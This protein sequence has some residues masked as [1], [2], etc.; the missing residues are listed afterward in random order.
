MK[1]P[2]AVCDANCNI[3]GSFLILF[4]V[5]QYMDEPGNSL[6]TILV[7]PTIQIQI[8]NVYLVSF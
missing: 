4:G 5:Y 8:Q 3:I 7:F 1:Y 2:I 6:L